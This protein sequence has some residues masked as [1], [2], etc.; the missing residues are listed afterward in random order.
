MIEVLDQELI[1]H[2]WLY[3][4]AFSK[5]ANAPLGFEAFIQNVLSQL[6]VEFPRQY[7]YTVKIAKSIDRLL[8]GDFVPAM[9]VSVAKPILGPYGEMWFGDSSNGVPMLAGYI[10]GD[11]KNPY[12]DKLGDANVHGL[13]VGATGQGKSVTLNNLIMAMCMLLPPWELNL[14]MSDAKIVEFKGYAVNY[15]LPHIRTIAATGD[16]EYVISALEDLAV[17]MDKRSSLFANLSTPKIADF[18]KAMGLCIPQNII[19]IDEFQMMFQYASKSSSVKRRLDAAI[20]KFVRLGRATGYHILMAS[21]EV[22]DSISKDVLSNIR[23]RMAMGCE[24]NI[25]EMV[26]G[27]DA[28]KDNLGK[29]GRLIVNTQSQKGSKTDN[30]D[31]RVPYIKTSDM[32]TLGSDMIQ[33]AESYG[34]GISMAFYDEQAM[35][36][37]DGYSSYLEKFTYNPTEV[38]LG[39][40]IYVTHDKDLVVKI[41]WSDNDVNN[42]CVVARSSENQYRG[43]IML[44]KNVQRYGDKI[45]HIVLSADKSFTGAEE[46][47]QRNFFEVSSMQDIGFKVIYSVSN[48]RQLCLKVDAS[49]FSNPR[50]TADTDK[51]FEEWINPEED[52]QTELNR[53]RFYYAFNMLKTD[54]TIQGQFS[55]NQ[56]TD[57][58]KREETIKSNLKSIFQMYRQYKAVNRKLTKEDLPI[59]YCWILGAQRILELG[60]D[61]KTK[62]QNMLKTF[63]LDTYKVNMRVVMI[64]SSFREMAECKTGFRW[65]LLDSGSKDESTTIGAKTMDL[66][67]ISSNASFLIDTVNLVYYKYKKM[68]FGN[69]I[70]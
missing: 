49:V 50:H 29:K 64:T 16:S 9:E 38:C 45:T 39:E 10:N 69:E 68:A 28:A 54:N 53:S 19:V 14:V 31:I 13:L 57:A 52:M 34:V 11:S 35:V 33:K 65:F 63:A 42:V 21:Q 62:S 18:R 56:I 17:D 59:T 30:I 48:R 61:A 70:F 41:P 3:N 37:E 24:A 46:L 47:G 40:P 8:A 58:V 51:L 32:T 36:Y 20:E 4:D 1:Q 66:P 7:P 2:S 26:L 12:Q 44:L 43:W 22:S 55:L 27:N 23:M 60:R 5:A 15:P 25:S 67:D 6:K